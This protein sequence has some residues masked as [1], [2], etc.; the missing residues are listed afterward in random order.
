V[1]SVGLVIRVAAVGPDLRAV[2]AA[3]HGAPP[4]TPGPRRVDEQQ[5]AVVRVATT[6]SPGLRPR[7]QLDGVP[8][9][10]GRDLE[11]RTGVVVRQRPSTM[12]GTIVGS[13]SNRRRELASQAS[14]TIR[15]Q[16]CR[17]TRIAPATLATGQ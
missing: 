5:V 14:C 11:A 7:E 8:G 2:A 16:P 9:Q 4:P 15:R 10:R 17:A 1:V 6:E 3:G 12:W 13:T